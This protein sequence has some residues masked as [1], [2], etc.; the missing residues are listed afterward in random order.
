MEDCAV[1]KNLAR[2]LDSFPQGYPETETG[3]EFEILSYLFTPDEAKLAANLKNPLIKKRPAGLL[4]IVQV[5]IFIRAYRIFQNN[6]AK[7]QPLS[8][9]KEYL[10]KF[11]TS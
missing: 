1:Y 3:I 5:L 11:R 8:G 10:V 9:R 4:N 2:R 6:V 7:K